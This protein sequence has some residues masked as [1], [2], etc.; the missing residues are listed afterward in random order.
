MCFKYSKNETYP[1]V[2]ITQRDFQLVPYP[3]ACPVSRVVNPPRAVLGSV[4]VV[5]IPWNAM[6]RCR[7]CRASQQETKDE[8]RQ[9][10][11]LR[12]Q[13]LKNRYAGIPDLVIKPICFANAVENRHRK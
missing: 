11:D 1:V 10:V 13:R 7:A 4:L 9:H 3:V 12:E 2:E 8:R 5:L 6:E